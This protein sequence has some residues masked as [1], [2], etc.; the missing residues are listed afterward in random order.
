MPAPIEHS[1]LIIPVEDTPQPYDDS[2]RE[3]T[4]K[5]P[6]H[7]TVLP[8]MNSLSAGKIVG[9][10]REICRQTHSFNVE[11]GKRILVGPE[12]AE[13]SVWGI[14]STGLYALHRRLYSTAVNTIDFMNPE[15][16]GNKYNPHFSGDDEWNTARRVGSPS[17]ISNTWSE[18]HQRAIKTVS[19]VLPFKDQYET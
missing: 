14:T 10:F 15:W 8:W 2:D 13:F 7:I 9:Q 11:Q 4:F 19:A 3:I 17:L 5:V 6:N 12:G 1:T 16:L 18:E